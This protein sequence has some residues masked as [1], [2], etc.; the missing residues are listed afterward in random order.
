MASSIEEI[1]E[2]LSVNNK[3][4]MAPRMS[5][6]YEEMAT[7]LLNEKLLLTALELHAEL[8]EAGK[9]LPIL[10]EFFSNPNNFENSNIKPE[11]FTPM[12]RSSSQATLDS[13][14]MTRYSEDGAGVDERVAI[15][16]FELRKARENISA[17]RANLTVVTELEGTHKTP[18]KS[19]EKNLTIELPIKPH[20]QR[21]L[22]FLINEYLLARSYKLT[23]ITFSDECE[24]QDFEDWQ[25]VGL[26]I[27]KPTKLLQIYREHMRANGYDKSPSVS[28][29]IQTDF[30]V[31]EIEEQKDNS[32]EMVEQIER[33][34]QQI[35]VLEQEKTALQEVIS[36][37][38]ENVIENP[39]KSGSC[40]TIRTINSSSTTPDKFELL[41]S[42]PRD[43]SITTQEPEEDDSASAVVSL[44]ETDPGDKE[45]TRLQLPRVNITEK[46]SVLPTASSRDL[47][48]KFKLELAAHCL[49]NVS[50]S[51]ISSMEESLKRGVTRDTLVEILTYILP[52]IV[53]NIILNKREEIIPLII[54]AI[55]LHSNLSEREKLLQ[56]LFNLK[57]RPQED[58]RQMILAGLVVMAKLA[59]EPLEGEEILTICWEQSQHKYPERRLLAVECCSVLASYTSASIRNSLML[60][61]LQQMLLED[62]DPVVRTSVVKTLAFLIALMDDPDKY[63]QCEELAL[64]ALHDT[65]S[66]VVET[67][68][69]ILLPVLAQWALSLKRLH[70]NLLP[71]IISKVKNQLKPTHSQASPNKDYVDEEKLVPSIGILQCI[72]PYTVLCVAD[73]NAV[74]A[75]IEN[76][77][78]SDLSEEFLVLCHS[79]II[80][81]RIF[82]EGPIDIGVLL[83]TFFSKSWEDAS[84]PELEWFTKK[85]VFDVLEMVKS[86][87]AAHENI[88]K[89]LLMYIHSLCVGFGKYITQF[90]I[91]T[92]FFP[93]VAELEK[94]LTTL[95]TD[96]KN[97]NLT[98]IPSYLIILSTLDLTEFANYF[99]QFLVVLSMSGTSISWL[100]IA[101]SILYAQEQ[102]QE[103]VLA[104]LWDGV[105]HQRSTVRCATATLF[106]SAIAH[107]SDRLANAK[108]VPAI[109]TLASDPEVGV[110]C[111]AI[112]S[113]G[114][115]IT[116]CK[117]REARDKARLTL[118]T[119]AKDSQGFSQ[120]L[121]TSLVST[122]AFI[123]P[124][125]PQNYIE[126]VIATQ[127][128]TIASFALQHSRKIELVNALV[129]A[130]SVLVYCP[131][132]SQC[133]SGIVLPG[134]RHLEILVNQC[135]PQQ[136][137]AVR[138]LLREAESK[139][140][141]SKPI[142]RTL[143]TSSGLSL[144]MATMNVGQGVEDMRQRMSKIFQQKTVS[145]SMPSIFR[146]K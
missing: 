69:S 110:R 40:G 55:H 74:R 146:K 9:E 1:K 43:M 67:A 98:L 33:L 141:L 128:S 115:I 131:L 81:P 72:L 19:S 73:T 14:D 22:N 111:A 51:I 28:I 121:A 133:V 94:Q 13:L 99:K 59:E 134:L 144:S 84:W 26:D 93:E 88:L 130:Y 66:I 126:D 7:K 17:L 23:S 48:I 83:N 53:P 104:S 138:S 78:S 85:L 57:K 132:S 63:F 107:V 35:I 100:Q 4:Y 58:E 117:V 108:I 65:S 61:M 87:D 112:S 145:P 49:A 70:V 47:P 124:T 75:C 16:E 10:K 54:S 56:L 102:I 105:V 5:I 15:L 92:A 27:P 113:L 135:L 6:S 118:E 18:D 46:S 119:I 37:N 143:S 12:P 50:G 114:R 109:V 137:D 64:T 95:S 139:Q 41:E 82:Y 20:E 96:K 62:K 52:R 122:F 30:A 140:D 101:A 11:P 103:Y 89:A 97:M 76:G 25:D 79:N 68:S 39:I 123:A 91:Q 60:S 34:Q 45:W 127:L 106:G 80:D 77:T 120:T 44:D 125:C 29:A 2:P 142:E 21:A 8:C 136:K 71:R 129:E 31:E 38:K 86:V 90:R 42:L 3:G 32:Q 36:S 116:E 24:D